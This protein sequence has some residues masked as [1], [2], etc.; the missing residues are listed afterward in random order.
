MIK[1][2][3]FISLL[4]TFLTL[5]MFSQKANI[6]E[7][8]EPA[9]WWT[10]MKT[11]QLQLLVYGKN[12]SEAKVSVQSS[13]IILKGTEKTDNPNYLFVN[14]EIAENAKD[15]NVPLIFEIKGKKTT[16]QYP[17]LP[18]RN[19]PYGKKGFNTADAIY[20]ITPDRFA[21][22]NPAT[23]NVKGYADTAKRKDPNGRHGGDIKG[24]SDHLDYIKNLGFNTLWINPLLENNMNRTSYHGYAITDFYKI[25]PRY[26]SNEEYAKL[27]DKCHANDMKVIMDFVLNHCGSNHW[28][29]NDRPASDWY[30]NFEEYTNSNFRSSTYLDPHASEFDKRIFEHGWFD[31]MMP[32]LNQNNKYM[33]TYLIQNTLW[34]I[35][36]VHLDGIRLD[37]Q[38]YSE[39][40]FLYDWIEAINK[41][42][43]EFKVVGEAWLGDVSYTAAFVAK[44]KTGAAYKTNMHY[45]TDFPL[46]DAMNASIN[47]REGWS[48]GMSRIYN[49]LAQDFLYGNAAEKTMIF[50]TNHDKSRVS[51]GIKGDIKKFKMQV[52][53]LATLRGIPQWY[54]GDEILLPGSK[55]KGDGV[56]R[57]D[58]PGGWEGD[59]VN[60]FTGKGLKK[61]QAEALEYT[62]KV[63]NWRKTSNAVIKGSLKQFVPWNGV[64]AYARKFENETVLI[65]V[66]NEEKNDVKLDSK[67]YA[68]VIQNHTTGLDVSSG[69]ELVLHDLKIP[70]KSVLILELK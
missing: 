8:I 57:K 66:N 27:I 16:W 63:F 44:N 23:D 61:D 24:I 50:L 68:E 60:V 26:G 38:P 53:L 15:G 18:R 34:W 42:Y 20:L 3:Y 39:M 30:H 25:D 32:D 65:L 10:G 33:A 17:L 4:S 12:I 46:S 14:I 35:E 28:W 58:M 56:I 11:R 52:A 45:V 40:N 37:T 2:I 6:I 49:V 51:E 62:R 29:H 48:E 31:R 67:R 41:E 54:Y 69:K 5:T 47:E 70:A 43:P 22:G 64:Y 7:R 13:A 36:M 59:S 55:D 9:N 1:R 19:D 21:D